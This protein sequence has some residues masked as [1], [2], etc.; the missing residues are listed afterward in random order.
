MSLSS[1]SPTARLLRNSRLFSLPQPLPRPS[2]DSSLAAGIVRASD[3]ATLPYPTHQALATPTSSRSRGDWGLKRPLPLRSTTN[4]TTPSVRIKALDTIEHITD[5]E[6][7][8]DHTRTLV[9]WQEM[10]IPLVVH[11]QRTRSSMSQVYGKPR[12]S[13]FEDSIDNTAVSEA[14]RATVTSDK[15]WKFDGPW[16]AGMKQGE[17]RYYLENVVKR[18]KMTFNVYL[19]K[20]IREHLTKGKMYEMRDKGAGAAE[21]GDIH[22][23]GEEYADYIKK[24]RSDTTLNSE[25]SRLIRDFLDL[26]GTGESESGANQRSPLARLEVRDVTD[27]GPP[28]THP[29]AGLSYLRTDS[30][31]E[32]HPVLGPLHKKLPIQARIV[33]GRSSNFTRGAQRPK[34][35][36]GGVITEL[37]TDSHET[38]RMDLETEG[39]AKIWV[40]TVQASVD[41][42]GRIDLRIVKAD[43]VSAMIAEGKVDKPVTMFRTQSEPRPFSS[44]LNEPLDRRGRSRMGYGLSGAS[45]G[46]GKGNRM[47]DETANA[48]ADSLLGI[49][50]QAK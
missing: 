17:F 21:A 25:L 22:I 36:V 50:D 11:E 23:T 39:G 2:H 30:F 7:A 45:A 1:R 15:R 13:V 43:D 48:R 38:A 12:K 20:H 28:S 8:A 27:A 33:S 14:E 31:L 26:P 19:R 35:G 49:L 29:S 10:N 32:N 42:R 44:R 4:T 3:T 40:H 18:K 24:L 9:K 47:S 16:I 46:L 37:Y 6:S 41:P 5:Y 34:L